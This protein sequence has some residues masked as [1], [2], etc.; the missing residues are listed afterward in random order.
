VNSAPH[1]ENTGTRKEMNSMNHDKLLREQIVTLLKGKGAHASFDEVVEG[2][3]A[4]LRGTRPE[5]A[6][7]SPWELLEHLRI[8]QWDLLEFSR[9]GNHKSPKFPDGYWPPTPAPPD[10]HAWDKS[11][12]TWRGDHKEFCAFVADEKTDLFAKIPHGNG[13]TVLREALVAADHNAYH[14]GQLVDLRRLLGAWPG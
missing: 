10:E 4:K 6:D 3:P 7:H 5:G 1:Y 2:L 9:D 13:Q 14:L 11:I 12:K 8:A